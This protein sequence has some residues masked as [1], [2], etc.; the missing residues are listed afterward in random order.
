MSPKKLGATTKQLIN[1]KFFIKDFFQLSQVLCQLEDIG[2]TWKSGK[3]PTEA[4]EFEMKAKF[5]YVENG[6]LTWAG[7]RDKALPFLT[8]E[9]TNSPLRAIHIHRDIR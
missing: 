5:L 3:L 2:V 8:Q 4:S 6:V 7:D 1:G 9:Y